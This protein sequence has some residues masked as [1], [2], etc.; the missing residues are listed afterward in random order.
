MHEWKVNWD[1]T[2]KGGIEGGNSDELREL[3]KFRHQKIGTWLPFVTL[4]FF[5][6]SFC[7]D[8]DTTSHES[9]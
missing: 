9:S 4:S 7:L 3:D 2:K 1:A 6:L 8:Q 5:S